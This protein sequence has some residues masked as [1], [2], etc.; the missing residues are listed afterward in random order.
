MNISIHQEKKEVTSQVL[1]EILRELGVLDTRGIAIAVNQKV[2]PRSQWSSY[3]VSEND[4]L[5]VIQATQGG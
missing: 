4:N 2:V 1:A 3:E 5:T